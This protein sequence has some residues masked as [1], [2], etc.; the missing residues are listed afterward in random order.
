MNSKRRQKLI[1]IVTPRLG[2]GEQVRV[3][4]LGGVG[5]VSVARKAVTAA[6][7]GVASG[8]TLIA[9][10][11]ARPMY[12]ALTDYRIFFV[13]QN[14]ATGGVGGKILMIL[15]RAAVSG[16]RTGKGML[17]LTLRAR[18]EIKGEEKG[19]QITFP[20]ASKSDGRQMVAALPAA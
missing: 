3:T 12:I 2:R 14:R 7:V 1:D 4:A 15:D 17:G 13:E 20:Y 16:V 10:V 11:S 5:S 19:L 18:L 8:G 9:N 6:V